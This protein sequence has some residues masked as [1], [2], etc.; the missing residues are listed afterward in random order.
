M[1]QSKP[2]QS[3]PAHRTTKIKVAL[4]EKALVPYPPTEVTIGVVDVPGVV[5]EV[6]D[7]VNVVTKGAAI[8]TSTGCKD[9]EEEATEDT[10]E[11]A[12]RAEVTAHTREEGEVEAVEA[13]DPL[14]SNSIQEVDVVE[15]EVIPNKDVV[16]DEEG[17]EEVNEDASVA[18]ATTINEDAGVAEATTVTVEADRVAA[19]V[20]GDTNPAHNIPAA[21][22]E[23]VEETCKGAVEVKDEEATPGSRSLTSA[24]ADPTT[25]TTPAEGVVEGEVDA[26]VVEGEVE[27]VVEDPVLLLL[28]PPLPEGASSVIRSHQGKRHGGVP[29]MTA[30]RCGATEG[31]GFGLGLGSGERER[32]RVGP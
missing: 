1:R 3:Q 25:G 8:I 22:V 6:D 29:P 32:S 16:E 10:V 21:V 5:A 13:G 23:N 4:H 14:T 24:T 19:V 11:E 18:R 27:A 7:D 20:V 12:G 2:A 26:V 30:R 28:A 31:F 9:D 17:V 15:L